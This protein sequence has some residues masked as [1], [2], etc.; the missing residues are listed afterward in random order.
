[1]IQ[2]WLDRQ[3]KY[4][5]NNLTKMTVGIYLPDLQNVMQGFQNL[6]LKNLSTLIQQENDIDTVDLESHQSKPEN[7][8]VF[9][10]INQRATNK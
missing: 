7:S 5:L 3:I 1:M 6:K 2:D 4:T 8:D 10:K 9:N